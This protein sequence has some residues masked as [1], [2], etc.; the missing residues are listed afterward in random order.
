MFT[1]MSLEPPGNPSPPSAWKLLESHLNA[2]V[3]PFT[4]R[5]QALSSARCCSQTQPSATGPVPPHASA[6]VT[7][8]SSLQTPTANYSSRFYISKNEGYL[9]FV[10][11]F[12]LS[13]L[14]NR[15]PQ[16]SKESKLSKFSSPGFS[17]TDGPHST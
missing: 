10:F 16:S 5:Q 12:P 8:H 13:F 17:V 11:S 15:C 1:Q 7:G 6:L 3:A 4:H 14:S 9:C 2:P